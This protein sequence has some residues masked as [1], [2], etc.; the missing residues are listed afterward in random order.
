[1]TGLT[2]DEWID[3]CIQRYLDRSYE[4]LETVRGFAETCYEQREG[5]FELDPEG[6]ADSDISYWTA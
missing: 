3:R 4:S 1:M 2:R 6:A 5:W